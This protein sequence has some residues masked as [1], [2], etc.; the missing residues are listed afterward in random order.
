MKARKKE[1]GF[2][3]I[4]LMIVVGIIGVLASVA[5]PSFIH[6][7]HKSKT[8]EVVY[9]L[10]KIASGFKAYVATQEANGAAIKIPLR[11]PGYC[12]RIA[13]SSV[14][15]NSAGKFRQDHKY[16]T[17]DFNLESWK[18]VLFKPDGNFYYR[19]Y[20]NPIYYSSS[21]NINGY[22]YAIGDLDCDGT[23]SRWRLNLYYRPSAGGFRRVGPYVY[24]GTETE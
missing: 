23:Y 1:E 11:S 10:Q 9:S 5:I 4:E 13:H 2:T 24:G 20:M 3:L 22:L 6:Y 21:G 17:R 8:T 14:C 12:P 16:V 18:S 15:K 19:Y 7:L